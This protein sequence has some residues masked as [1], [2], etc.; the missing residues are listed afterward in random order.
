MTGAAP[1]LPSPSPSW[2]LPTPNGSELVVLVDE[3]GSPTGSAPKAEVHT[4][5]TPL[6]LAFS[7]HVFLTDGRVL[8]TRRAVGKR[9]FPGV[10][11]NAFCGHP[12]PGE[13]I[14]DAV[15]RRAERELGLAL[16][17]LELVLPRFRYRAADASGVVENELCPVYSATA[18]A[19]PVPAVDEV[20]DWAWTRP[21]ALRAAVEAAPYAF[22]PWLAL[23][24]AQWS[25]FGR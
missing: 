14:Q 23:Q 9:T 22:S 5:A 24:L 1:A 15:L 4:A 18:E 25:G 20:A 11:S 6:H 19:D 10:W 7:C 8:V 17:G 16:T 2:P 21:E 13:S 12:A 3:D